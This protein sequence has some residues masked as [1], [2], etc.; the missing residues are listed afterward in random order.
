[1]HLVNRREVIMSLSGRCE[2]S[3]IL[4]LSLDSPL[5]SKGAIHF[6]LG[7]E[8]IAG[9]LDNKIGIMPKHLDLQ[10][11]HDQTFKDAMSFIEN[12]IPDIIGISTKIGSLEDLNATLVSISDIKNRNEHYKPKLIFGGVYA[13]FAARELFNLA[14]EIIGVSEQR[15][16]YIVARQGEYP[17]EC[18]IKRN[19]QDIS[20]IPNISYFDPDKGEVISTPKTKVPL[21]FCEVA[22]PTTQTV[23]QVLDKNGMIWSEFSRGCQSFCTFCSIMELRGGRDLEERP[24]ELVIQNFEEL[25]RIGVHSVAF[26]DD[27][28]P[29]TS[30]NAQQF[31]KMMITTGLN[32]R[33]SFS[34]STRSTN[35]I[36]PGDDEEAKQ[37]KLDCFHNFVQAGLKDIFIGLE[38]FSPPQLKRY[39]ILPF[40]KHTKG[41]K[42]QA[43]ANS[44]VVELLDNS[45]VT[46]V[47]GFI[48]IDPLM[49]DINELEYNLIMLKTSKMYR[50]VTNP[51][52]VLRVQVGT[53][54]ENLA[55]HAGLI[56]EKNKVDLVFYD[57]AYASEVVAIIAQ[58]TGNWN[59]RKGA[60]D[61]ALKTLRF[62]SF[63]NMDKFGEAQKT[64]EQIRL[65]DLDFGLELC[66]AS[67]QLPVYTEN[68][69][70][71]DIRFKIC[72]GERKP[73]LHSLT[74]I[75]LEYEN[76]RRRL[77]QSM[78]E[79][80]FIKMNEEIST[81]IQQDI[82][83]ISS[84]IDKLNFNNNNLLEQK[85]FLG[86]R[87]IQRIESLIA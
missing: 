74:S 45:E 62:A 19:F 73:F 57:S 38:S 66:A 22:L 33:I 72:H 64:I 68:E 81:T 5:F 12:E 24:A 69:G 11:D 83:K 3:T 78:L 80:E 14:S 76:K 46:L 47:A 65:I 50:H 60:T 26:A 51:L 37:W 61:Y 70:K 56:S 54:Y 79:F 35:I 9:H 13:T 67:K 16:I 63:S 2:N 15:Y 29:I 18:L 49:I 84:Y 1:M 39:G 4:L 87:D 55:K 23:R 17:I 58:I 52:H 53:A 43:D 44:Q 42:K 7:A 41:E 48:P 27:D 85:S 77:F 6:G 30:N 59:A 34:M 31:A 32:K 21:P 20:D 28:F 75:L 25:A 10:I 40:G 8:S 86:K 36:R 71:P 82:V